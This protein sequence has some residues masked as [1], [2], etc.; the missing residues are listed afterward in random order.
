[1]S[2]KDLMRDKEFLAKMV[3]LG[4]VASLVFIGIGAIFIIKELLV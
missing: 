2:L 1:M 4:Y 3:W